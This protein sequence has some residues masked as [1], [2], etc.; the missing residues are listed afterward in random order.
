MS[1]SL[2]ETSEDAATAVIFVKFDTKKRIVQH[3]MKHLFL[4]PAL[5]LTAFPLQLRAQ[6]P[7]RPPENKWEV[8][9]FGG[10][11]GLS[12]RTLLTPISGNGMQAVSLRFDSSYVLGARVTENLGRFFGAELE[13]NFKN[14]PLRLSNLSPTLSRLDLEH[15]VHTITYNGLIYL[16]DRRAKIRPFGSVGA[17]ASF[18]EVSGASQEEGVMQG[19]DIRNRWKFAFSFGGGAKFRLNRHW[20]V[21]LDVR[22]H[23]S[24]VPNYGL[25]RQAPVTDG[26]QGAGLRPDGTLHNWYLGAGIMYTFTPRNP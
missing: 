22:D 3:L 19:L 10:M 25:P 21:R 8:S 9:F 1:G 7:L 11:G 13:Y 15:R 23:V 24:G 5:I 4:L 16:A 12:N 14:A 2:F 6:I 18:F 26:V 17:G 20:G